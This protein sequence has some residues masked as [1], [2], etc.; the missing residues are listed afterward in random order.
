MTEAKEPKTYLFIKELLNE[1][2]QVFKSGLVPDVKLPVSETR[3]EPL[4]YVK[5]DLVKNISQGWH[6]KH[7]II[8]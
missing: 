7:N 5:N 1:V 3:A 2:E 4:P 6:Y 8:L